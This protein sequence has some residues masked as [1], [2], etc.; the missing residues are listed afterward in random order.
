MVVAKLTYLVANICGLVTTRLP[1][2]VRFMTKQNSIW[3]KALIMPLTIWN[4][5][6]SYGHMELLRRRIISVKIGLFFQEIT[7]RTEFLGSNFLLPTSLTG[8]KWNF[9]VANLLLLISNYAWALA[10]HLVL[11]QSFFYVMVKALPGELSCT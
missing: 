1:P 3:S 7:L 2:L 10:S 4:C 5:V 11:Q 8:G 6:L 9:Q